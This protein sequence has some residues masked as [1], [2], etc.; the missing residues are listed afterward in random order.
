MNTEK[1]W[2]EGREFEPHPGQN[3]WWYCPT[4]QKKSSIFLSNFSWKINPSNRIRTSD[5]RMSALYSSTVLRSTNWAIKGYIEEEGVCL[6]HKIKGMEKN[7]KVAI[8]AEDGFDPSTSG[9]W[10]QHA[11]AAPLCCRFPWWRLRVDGWESEF[12][13]LL[14]WKDSWTKFILILCWE[15]KKLPS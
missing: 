12:P 2:S 10:A 1:E 3:F 13:V 9:L 8:L 5:L 11:S 4:P 7:C 14:L 15:C 6:D